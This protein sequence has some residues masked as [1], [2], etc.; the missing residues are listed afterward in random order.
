MVVL[1][2]PVD[3][4]GCGVGL[5]SDAGGEKKKLTAGPPVSR[6]CQFYDGDDDDEDDDGIREKE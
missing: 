6:Y 5:L 3:Q 4:C 1:K 2:G